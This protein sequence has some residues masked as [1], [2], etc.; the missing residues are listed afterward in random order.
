MVFFCPEGANVR[1]LI[2]D[3]EENHR[4]IRYGTWAFTPETTTKKDNLLFGGQEVVSMDT[5]GDMI[6]VMVCPKNANP[7]DNVSRT[8]MPLPRVFH[9]HKSKYAATKRDARRRT[10][11]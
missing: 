3:L 11:E 9:D 10:P 4:I 2:E 6:I 5:I 8:N 7:I 1:F